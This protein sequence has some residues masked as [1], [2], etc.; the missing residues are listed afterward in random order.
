MD[1]AVLTK[2]N[3]ISP[4]GLGILANLTAAQL[5]EHGKVCIY[6]GRDGT[7]RVSDPNYCPILLEE[8]ESKALQVLSLLGFSDEQLLEFLKVREEVE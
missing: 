2:T 7:I 3:M 5:L 4:A 1:D 8:D 6:V